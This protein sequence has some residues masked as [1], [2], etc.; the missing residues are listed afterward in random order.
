MRYFLL[1]LVLLAFSVVAILG[2]RGRHSSQPPIEIFPDMDHQPKVKFQ[3]T[4][5]FFADGQ[6][7]RPQ[8][9]GTVA[10]TMPAVEDYFHTGKMG[11]NWGD[12]FPKEVEVNEALLARGQERYRIDCQVC[13]GAV[14]AGNGIVS[15]YG[16]NGIASYH[17]DRL[18]QMADGEIF[19]TITNGKGQMMS[20]GDKVSVKD[21][22]AIIAYVRAL[23]R[24]QNATLNDVPESDRN[25]LTTTP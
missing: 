4:S 17:A 11:A 14:G 21:R 23:Q 1:T 12:G 8:V 5:E 2:F 16:F 24:S 19:N 15:K 3:T 20:Y 13:H 10:M 18:R 25:Q 7:A 6:G 22:W 9:P